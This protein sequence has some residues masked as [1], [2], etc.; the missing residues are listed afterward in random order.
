M[1]SL[2]LLE[3]IQTKFHIHRFSDDIVTIN[4]LSFHELFDS[5]NMLCLESCH[6]RSGID[7]VVFRKAG[8][9]VVYVRL[10][11]SPFLRARLA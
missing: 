10:N 7:T 11:V 2:E 5:L 1:A 3:M 8:Y 9:R 4:L 6:L